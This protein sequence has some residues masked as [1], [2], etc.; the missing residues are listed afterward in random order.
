MNINWRKT[1]QVR[2]QLGTLLLVGL[3]V[4]YGVYSSSV[5]A[6]VSTEQKSVLA[7]SSEFYDFRTK[8]PVDLQPIDC[9]KKAC[10]ALTFDDGPE[11]PFTS[12]LLDV[13]RSKQVAAS[14]FVIGFKA[15]AQPT[16][17]R[18]MY[19]EGHDVENHSWDH[20]D[21]TKLTPER[22]KEEVQK[23]QDAVAAA[24]VPAPTMFRPPYGRRTPKIRNEIGLP[25]M[26]WDVDPKDWGETDVDKLVDKVVATVRGGSI[27]VMHANHQITV[28]AMPR[29]I[30]A[31][32]QKDY[33]LIPISQMLSG[34]L[35]PNHEYFSAR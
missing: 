30:D 10:V 9:V 31:L 16:L 12:E 25:T 24:D 29:I 8:L 19:L 14:F 22:I 11:E 6:L 26:L 13:L 4:A 28:T 32:R 2:L 7:K 5:E 20:A 17:T 18:R 23:T 15:A 34:S 3:F 27:V 21:F 33:Q 1:G 35:E